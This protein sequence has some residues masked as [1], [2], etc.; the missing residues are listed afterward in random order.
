MNPKAIISKPSITE[1]ILEFSK[2]IEPKPPN[3]SPYEINKTVKPETNNKEPRKTL[4]LLLV[5]L[6]PDAY[7]IYPGTSGITHGEKNEIRPAI[8]ATNIAISKL[9]SNTWFIKKSRISNYHF[10]HFL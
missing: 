6:I 4:L 2:I 3:K 10:Q 1:I 7:E 8:A 5:S 9:P